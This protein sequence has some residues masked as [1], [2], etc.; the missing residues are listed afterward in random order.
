MAS[1]VLPRQSHPELE[2]LVLDSSWLPRSGSDDLPLPS[3]FRSTTTAAA[4]AAAVSMPFGCLQS[5]AGSVTCSNTVSAAHSNSDSDSLS[6]PL[7]F[8]PFPFPVN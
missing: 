2:K 1:T 4:A 6:V 8:S 5:L 7:A 3:G